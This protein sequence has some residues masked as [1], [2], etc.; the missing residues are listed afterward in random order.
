MHPLADAAALD[1]AGAPRRGRPPAT[2][3]DDRAERRPRDVVGVDDQRQQHDAERRRRSATCGSSVDD[4]APV[5]RQRVDDRQH[6][7]RR[8]RRHQHGVQRGVGDADEPGDGVPEDA[9]GD[10]DHGSPD[11]RRCAAPGAAAGRG[12]GRGC[13]PRTSPARSRAAEEGE[14]RVARVEHPEA[15]RRRARRRPAARRGRPEGASAAAWRGA[16]RPGRP[17]RRSPGRGTTRPDARPARAVEPS[18]PP[19]MKR[20]PTHPAELACP[21]CL[22]ALGD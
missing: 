20:P 8:G 10:T 11:E 5:E 21:C 7:R 9:G 4:V 13:R 2:Q 3:H 12:P 16:D 18:D 15:A 14:R 22:P 19:D 6:Q 1:R 17:R